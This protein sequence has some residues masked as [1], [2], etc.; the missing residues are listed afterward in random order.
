MSEHQGA[1]HRPMMLA[2]LSLASVAGMSTAAMAVADGGAAL[3]PPYTTAQA[4]AGKAVYAASC[5]SC[6]GANLEGG[7]GPALVGAD[8]VRKWADGKKSAADL[9]AVVHGSM[10]LQ[11]P[12]SLGAADYAAIIA[13]ILSRNGYSAGPSAFDPFAA[14]AAIALAQPAGGNQ[15][16]DTAAARAFLAPPTNPGKASSTGP[17]DADLRHPRDS[18]WLV[19]NKDLGSTRY[20]ALDQINVGN[21]A[22]LVAACIFQTGET[23]SFQA[24][25][26]VFGGL[27]YI[28]TA[29]ATHAIDPAT[30]ERKW[31]HVYAGQQ[32]TVVSQSRG[33]AIYRGSLFRVTPNGHLIALDARTGKLL[34]DVLTSDVGIGHWLS[35]APVAY[36]GLVFMGEAGADWGANGHVFAFDAA[37]GRHVWTFDVIPTGKQPGAAS[38]GKGAEHGGGSL[39]A[40]LSIDPDK[41][42]LYASI[43]NPAPDYD[44]ALRP[45]DNLYTDSI[46][47]LQYRTGKLAWYAQQVPHDVHD[48]DTAATPTLYSQDGRSFVSVANK[49]GWVYIYDRASHKLL[50]KTE[51]SPHENIDAPLSPKG[52]HHCPGITGGVQWNGTAYSPQKRMLY[53]NSVHWCGTTTLTESRYI[54]GS[55]YAGAKHA[56]DPVDTARGF[57]TALDA[58]TGKVMW[59][60]EAATPMLAALTPTA[61]GVIFTGS[62]DGSFLVLDAG[63]GATLYRFNTGGAVAG[64]ASTY[65]VGDRQYVAVTSGN[66]SRS[67]WKTT[68]AGTVVIFTLPNP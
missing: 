12:G 40:S 10:P 51:V 14:S 39:W 23:G 38:W 20:S 53:V 68:G 59:K 58:E 31:S 49:G 16:R 3:N 1:F 24:S 30:C 42:L 36:D 18:S 63:S 64:A 21:A 4:G 5:A 46:V 54:A 65:Q 29:Y 44:G 61:G 47:A 26:V 41:G 66:A 60:R 37:T 6:H 43:G 48:W 15:V 2:M 7:A 45:G 50:A 22:R 8:F 28:T 55:S 27:M 32:G 56:W 25:P 17:D 9:Y 19:Y 11:A 35:M 62:L 52:T 13:H 67:T 33:V 34:W 57:T